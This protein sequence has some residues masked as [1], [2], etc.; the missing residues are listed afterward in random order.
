M[1]SGDGIDQVRAC[2]VGGTDLAAVYWSTAT[3]ELRG[4]Y[5]N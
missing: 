2:V 3:Q 4:L 5:W 1:V